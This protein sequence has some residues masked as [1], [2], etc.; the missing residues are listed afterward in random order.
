[1]NAPH[2]FNRLADMR[3]AEPIQ[4]EPPEPFEHDTTPTPW[5]DD[6]LPGSMQQA[7]S[8]I[9]EHVIAPEAL[10]GMAVLAA[11]AH[12]AQRIANAQHP[13]AAVDIMPC[14]L[15]ALSL[16]NSGDRKSAAFNLATR[17]I[18]RSEIEE[19]QK[20]QII[21]DDIEREAAAAKPTE[22]EA[23]RQTLP[24]DPRTLYTEATLE[25][26]VRDY[27]KG[28]RPAMSWSTD[29]GAQFFGGH[30]MKSDTRAGAL[31]ALTRLFDGRGVERDRIGLESGSGVR[32]NVR[33]GLFLSAQPSVVLS[34]LSDPLL[35]EQGL[36]PRFLLSAPATMAGTRLLTPDDLTRRA[37]ADSR[38]GR[39]WSTLEQMNQ[40]R[41]ETD[42]YGGL[43]LPAVALTPEAVA[44]W[45]EHFNRTE[46]R[47]DPMDG[48][49]TG[50]LQAFGGRGGE[51]TARVAAVFAVW[52]HYEE[53]GEVLQVGADDMRR[54][55]R[56]VDY[57]LAEW[58][59]ISD[60]VA[61][62]AKEC[63]AFELLKF[64]QRDPAKWA[65]FTKTE[66]ATKGHR[67][68]RKDKDRRNAALDE[69][70]KRRWLVFD[71]ERFRLPE[72]S[73]SQVAKAKT[74]NS[75]N[76]KGENGGV[77][78]QISRIS[79]SH[80]PKTVFQTPPAAVDPA[81]GEGSNGH[82]LPSDFADDQNDTPPAPPISQSGDEWVAAYNAADTG[83]TF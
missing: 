67:P 8:A 66:A 77:I 75:A 14:S 21:K 81:V 62:S 55:C 72:F 36:L 78:S 29:E 43:V 28:S 68:L 40:A 58:L 63:D 73:F 46:R 26:I 57:S 45:L 20:H 19:R 83:E 35:R 48:D 50:S 32:F 42:E 9:S 56:L 17:P 80:E 30:T 13:S 16:A 51:L 12:V 15:F 10:A 24:R 44:D 82:D 22:R 49:L 3:E 76:R 70:V 25:K 11:V 33:F 47:L 4:P 52:R 41:E 74:A 64:L 7:A 60:T 18:T 1:M 39:Y 54:A 23:I 65:T 53:G 38:L 31:G 79:L 6:C 34:S 61:L 37:D 27:V 59:R 5:P 69:L 2:D 71:G